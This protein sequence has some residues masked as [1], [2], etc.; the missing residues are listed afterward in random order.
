MGNEFDRKVRACVARGPQSIGS[1]IDYRGLM[2]YP[3][4]C[5]VMRNKEIMQTMREDPSG[6]SK[7]RGCRMRTGMLEQETTD[8]Y[9]DD[10]E[11]EDPD[12][13]S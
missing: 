9:D 12:E 7:P 5:G 8:H 13:D 10:D 11:D 1:H 6:Q 4:M 3:R 2:S